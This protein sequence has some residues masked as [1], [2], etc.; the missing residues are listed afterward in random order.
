MSRIDLNVDIGEGFPNDEALLSFA[1]SANICCGEH[2]GSWELTLA[3]IELCRRKGVRVGMHPGYADRES[4]GRKAPQED[5][6]LS[7]SILGQANE[8]MEAFP[9][10]YV[11]PHGAWYN[12]IVAGETVGRFDPA[13]PLIAIVKDYR[14]P[15]MMLPVYKGLPAKW[16]I[17]EGFADRAYLPD[18]SLMPRTQPGAV[19]EDPDLVRRQ[20]LRIAPDIDSIC[21]HGDAPD[22]LV[23]AELVK[24]TLM[25]AG[26]EVASGP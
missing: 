3:T 10:A 16:V 7:R 9:A 14:I 22:A 19:F 5:T 1:T 23:F 6:G 25:D 8:F 4:M 26:Y 13:A 11:K 24:K 12:Q 20:V 21:L 2:A 17:R 18:G 15:A